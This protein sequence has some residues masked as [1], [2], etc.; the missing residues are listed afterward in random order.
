MDPID[1]LK[2]HDQPSDAPDPGLAALEAELHAALRR[3][4]APAGFTPQVLARTGRQPWWSSVS[5]LMPALALIAIVIST[6]SGFREVENRRAR[7]A[8]D[9]ARLALNLTAEKLEFAKAKVRYHLMGE[10]Q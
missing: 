5:R 10:L 4:P 7:I 2:F 8:A 6:V 9:Q 1:N 3:Q